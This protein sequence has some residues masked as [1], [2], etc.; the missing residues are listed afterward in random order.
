VRAIMPVHVL[1]HPVDMAPLQE[2]ARAHGLVIVADAAEALGTTYRGTPVARASDVAAVSFNGNKVVTAGGGGAV[3]TDDEALA[4][5]AR[6]LTTQAKDDAVEWIHGAIGFNYRLTNLQAAVGVAQ[7]EHLDACLRAKRDHAAAYARA[8]GDLPLTLPREAPWAGSTWWLYTVLV[9]EP[10][11]G[12]SRPA[13]LRALADRGIET[14]PLWSPLSTQKPFAG[15]QAYRIE[16]AVE[17][18]RRSLSLPSSV[19][20]S[21]AELDT[22]TGALHELAR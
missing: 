9:D 5:R 19:G 12:T 4:A 8:L 21:A 1:G 17:L 10:R 16:H 18:H 7:L 11:F 15:C 2:A 22:V 14:R 20:L 3:V 6:Y 13:L